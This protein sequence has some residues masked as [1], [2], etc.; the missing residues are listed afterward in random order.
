MS[1]DSYVY[2][3]VEGSPSNRQINQSQTSSISR[4]GWNRDMNKCILKTRKPIPDA[5]LDL[6]PYSRAE[7]IEK[8]QND[9][10]W[11]GGFA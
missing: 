2:F 4:I 6:K 5:L 9:S 3:I 1:N 8:L 10:E 7:I 11:H